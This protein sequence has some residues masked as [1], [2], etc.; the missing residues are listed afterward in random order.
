LTAKDR[1]I[2]IRPDE[3]D[4]NLYHIDKE[5]KNENNNT[6]FTQTLTLTWNELNMLR[7]SLNVIMKQESGKR[8]MR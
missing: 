4:D 1:P 3:N 2:I 8:G 5:Q 7:D 6:N